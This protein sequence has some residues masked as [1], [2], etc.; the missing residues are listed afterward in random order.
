MIKCEL[1]FFFFRILSILTHTHGE[2][3]DGNKE[4]NSGIYPKLWIKMNKTSRTII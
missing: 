2:K 3:E 4:T 1:R